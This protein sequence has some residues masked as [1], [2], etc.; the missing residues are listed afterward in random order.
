MYYIDCC[1]NGEILIRIPLPNLHD[2]R[3]DVITTTGMAEPRIEDA[4]A[5]TTTTAG[6]GDNITTTNDTTTLPDVVS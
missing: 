1:W 6:G 5:T 2:Y 4:A 3:I